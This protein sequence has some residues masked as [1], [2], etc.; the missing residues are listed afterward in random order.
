MASSNEGAI[1][2]TP[3]PDDLVILAPNERRDTLLHVIRSARRRVILSLFRCDD[4]KVLDEL[5]EALERN[6]QV[7]ALLTQRA[8]GWEKRLKD[9]RVFLE[10]LGAVVHR[11]EGNG[12][13]YHAK[14]L[15]VD[16]G[17]AV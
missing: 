4:S 8:K 14:Y 9:L 7:E 15:V 1:D 5:A 17:P 12:A 11:Y 10:S 6:V 3:A 13:K 16:D 2:L